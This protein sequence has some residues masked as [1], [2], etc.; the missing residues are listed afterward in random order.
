MPGSGFPGLYIVQQ[1][2]AWLRV[3]GEPPLALSSGD[4]VVLP[5][6]P[7]HD[8]VSAPQLRAVSVDEFCANCGADRTSNVEGGGGGRSSVV[9]TFCF[10]FESPNAQRLLS[11]VKG[12]V[13]LRG[14]QGTAWTSQIARALG[15]MLHESDGAGE[16]EIR[17]LGEV[18][19]ATGLRLACRT[20]DGAG[21]DTAVAMALVFVHGDIAAAWTVESLARRVGVSRSSFHDRFSRAMGEAPG[22]YITRARMQEAAHLLRATDASVD[23]VAEAV[24]YSSR[25]SFA[26]AFRRAFGRSPRATSGYPIRKG[27]A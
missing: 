1:G 19:F 7:S 24:G 12:T 11:L 8:L 10:R 2:S 25:S 16:P 17:R 13:V 21:A 14:A 26:F 9:D 6:G 3:E 5:R 20:P 18:L 23:D 15:A 27:R 22:D 4:V